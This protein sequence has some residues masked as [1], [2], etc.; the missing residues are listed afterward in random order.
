MGL[1]ARLGSGSRVLDLGCA[2]GG[3]ALLLAQEFGCFVVAADSDE[4][5]LESVRRRAK[6][7]SLE[8]QIDAVTVDYGA[9]RFRDGEFSAIIAPSN[10]VYSLSLSLT[11]LRRY[12]ALR[13]RLLVCH[14]VRVGRQLGAMADFWRKMLGEALRT[15]SGILQQVEQAGYEPELIQALSDVELDELYRNAEQ[16]AAKVV[17]AHPARAQSLREELEAHRSQ[18]G[19]STVSF[20]AVLGRRKEAGEKPLPS[21]ERG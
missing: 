2:T 21:R 11:R 16:E 6:A 4:A 18:A 13:G 17:Q 19:K 14:P 12:L 9:P 10:S 5:S 15:P 20:A 3:V 8:S 1:A 7:Q